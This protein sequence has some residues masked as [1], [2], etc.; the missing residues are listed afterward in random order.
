M[1]LPVFDYCDFIIDSGPVSL[2]RK[3]QTTQNKRLRVS[4]GLRHTRD[5]RSNALHAL[6]DM[7]KLSF[8]RKNRLKL[9]MFKWS[10]LQ[11]NVVNPTRVLRDNCDIKLRVNRPILESFRLSPLYI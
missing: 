11:E 7:Q 5:I 1:I 3:L 10:K 9:V 2:V 6:C 8:H 4:Q